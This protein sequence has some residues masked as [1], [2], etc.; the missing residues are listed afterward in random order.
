M[1]LRQSTRVS[2]GRAVDFVTGV[3]V[4][5]NANVD[6]GGLECKSAATGDVDAVDLDASSAVRDS[7]VELANVTSVNQNL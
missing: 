4:D 7:D 2:F 5:A 3:F 1:Y 6:D